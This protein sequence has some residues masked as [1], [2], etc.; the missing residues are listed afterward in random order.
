[1]LNIPIGDAI[2]I[3]NAIG[4][5]L[6]LSS[7]SN[8]SVSISESNI[9]SRAIISSCVDTSSPI[10]SLANLR[11]DDN[12]DEDIETSSDELEYDFEYIVQNG[13]QILVFH[14]CYYY[15]HYIAKDT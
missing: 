5:P 14:N 12:D 10:T 1:M 8:S 2:R 7:S 9:S 6:S 13:A 15:K 3:L 11:L 4:A